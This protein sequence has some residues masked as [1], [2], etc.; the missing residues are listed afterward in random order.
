[1]KEIKLYKHI[2]PIVLRILHITRGTK[3]VGTIAY[4]RES[5]SK[6]NDIMD[7]ALLENFLELFPESKLEVVTITTDTQKELYENTYIR[8]LSREP[9]YIQWIQNLGIPDALFGQ[10]G[11]L[12]P[13]KKTL[14]TINIA[15]SDKDYLKDLEKV[16]EVLIPASNEN[17]GLFITFEAVL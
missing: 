2:D 15:T 4:Y 8:K 16:Y 5:N 3:N 11:K 13:T 1:M 6:T 7:T 9:V 10:V 12:Y 17:E 14:F